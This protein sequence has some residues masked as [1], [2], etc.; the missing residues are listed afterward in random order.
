MRMRRL[1]R[2]GSALLE[3]VLAVLIMSVAGLAVVGL[4]QK[5]MIVSFKSREQAACSRMTQT[6]S[7]RLKNIDFYLLFASDSQQAQHGLQA[8]Y[9]YRATL[10]GILTTLQSSR[11][12]RFRVQVLFLRRDSSDSNGD[13]LTSDL[14]AFNDGNG[15]LADDYDAGVRYQDQNA[16]GDYYDTFT[17]GGRTVAEQPD[18]HIKRVTVD[19]FRRGRLVCSQSQLVSL[20]QLTGDYNPS[21][22]AVL[23]LLISTPSNNA[24]LY[25]ADTA[26]LA[27][28]RALA[29]SKAYPADL[30]QLRSDA[31]SPLVVAGETDALSTVRLYLDGSGELSSLFADGAGAFS[32]PS[33]PVTAALAEGAHV[34]RAQAVKAPYSSPVT[35][36]ALVYDVAAPGITAPTPIGTAATRSPFVAATLAD[37]GISTAVTSGVCADVLT[38]K[39]DGVE[40]A[41]RY[42]DGTGRLVWVDSATGTSPVLSTGSYTVLVEGGDYAGY[43]ATASWTFTLS[44]P[45]TDHSAPSIANRSP[46]GMAGS[47]LPVVSVRVFD[48]QSGIIP[49]SIALLLDGATVVDSATVGSAYDPETGTVSFTP[50]SAFAPG[51]SHS[52]EIR[53]SHWATDPADK[54]TSTDSWWFTV[55]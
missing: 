27:A 42:D 49:S 35:A 7:A 41:H 54:V 23:S 36:R 26:G 17:S 5:A 28:S 32:G 4:L 14:V 12:D 20:E 44:L 52:V 50:S 37:A 31:A 1:G 16:D 34:L 51:S 6:A 18:T 45:V 55:P 8:A 39:V 19:V 38:M 47:Q 9:P 46:I 25:K 43:K 10:D 21:S 13:G 11:F 15:D 33:A 53:A 29:V 30:V 48:N 2:R 22:E 3:T 40:V 24:Y